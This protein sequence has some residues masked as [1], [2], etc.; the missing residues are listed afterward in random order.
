MII[1]RLKGG[2]GNQLF[3]YAFA[4]TIALRTNRQ[5][6]LDLGY[7]TLAKY[8]F[9]P[10]DFK[11]ERLGNY[12]LVDGSIETSYNEFHA[13]GHTAYI[14]EHFDKDKVWA[15]IDNPEMKAIL[16][17]GY[18]QDQFYFTP[19]LNQIRNEFKSFLNSY[20]PSRNLSGDLIN[21]RRQTVAVH[22]R[23]T[24]YLQ[25][26]I[27]HTHGI[28]EADY[29][30]QAVAIMKSR[31]SS[32]YFYIFSDDTQEAD[33]L[34]SNLLKEQTN[35]S[36]ILQQAPSKD[37]DLIELALMSRCKNFIIANSSFS[38]WGSYLSDA[39]PKLVVAPKQWL[40]SENLRREAEGIVLQS[41]IRI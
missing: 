35:I 11:L 25:P 1:L 37:N 3:Q 21:S 6:Y 26:S 40:L 20:Y 22:L 29:Y 31:L 19:F 24:D 34:F 27:L 4:R 13:A 5:L 28:C 9:T 17:D 12:K 41:W 14:Y 36:V 7:L 32:P 39:D 18:F 30:Q 16:L 8:R 38:W 10:R 15:T 2:L 33:R 23:R